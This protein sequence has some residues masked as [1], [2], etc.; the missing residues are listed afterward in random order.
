MVENFTGLR[1]QAERLRYRLAAIYAVTVPARLTE[2]KDRYCG[3]GL[4]DWDQNM[5]ACL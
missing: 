5:S 1:L 2:A 3:G 4:D